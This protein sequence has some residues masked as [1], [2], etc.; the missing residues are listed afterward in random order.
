[1]SVGSDDSLK[2]LPLPFDI[3]SA[4]SRALR[5]SGSSR[6]L[7]GI[8][9]EDQNIHIKDGSH[10]QQIPGFTRLRGESCPSNFSCVQDYTSQPPYYHYSKLPPYPNQPGICDSQP[11][12]I[13]INPSSRLEQVYEFSDISQQSFCSRSQSLSYP[14]F[15]HTSDPYTQPTKRRRNT[16]QCS[17]S[18]EYS[19]DDYSPDHFSDWPWIGLLGN[20][21][22]WRK[23]NE[24]GTEMVVT[25]GGR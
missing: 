12:L 13:D 9:S 14:D 16:M 17:G 7:A 5:I 2:E 3:S 6:A 21:P 15:Y 23:F 10:M 8:E 4:V 18:G 25:K 24:V 22:L 1:M 20:K 19:S 11:G